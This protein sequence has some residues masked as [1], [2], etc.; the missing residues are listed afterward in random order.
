VLGLCGSSSARLAHQSVARRFNGN[1]VGL[2]QDIH[3]HAA[4]AGTVEEL[5][6]AVDAGS[7]KLQLAGAK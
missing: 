7:D 6:A 3:E 2:A 1:E 4:Q 5:L